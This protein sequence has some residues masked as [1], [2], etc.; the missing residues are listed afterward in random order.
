MT[1]IV[2]P[3]GT[4]GDAGFEG[5]GS[6]ADDRAAL[7]LRAFRLVREVQ[8][9][10]V[11]SASDVEAMV[12]TA[13]ARG[14]PEATRAAL[15]LDVVRL[16]EH[17]RRLSPQAVSRL[18]ARA[19][20]DSDPIMTA[21]ALAMG[22]QEALS[23]QEERSVGADRD[24][25]HASVLL[26]GVRGEALELA[27]AHIEC[28]VAYDVRNLWEL[29]TDHYRAAEELV[30]GDHEEF[31]LLPV[32]RFNVAELHLNWA[33]ALRE[34]SDTEGLRHRV[35]IA[36]RAL[37]DAEVAS[38]PASWATE[39]RIFSMLL[40]AI[41]PPEE[42]LELPIGDPPAVGTYAGYVVLARALREGDLEL[43]LRLAGEATE[44]IDPVQCPGA[45]SLA[46]CL[47]G[48]LESELAGAV[49]AG[50]AYGCHLARLRWHNRLASLA[51]AESLLHG[52]RLRSE[53]T[54]LAQHAYLDD[55]TRLGNR[56]ALWRHLNRLLADGSEGIGI[57]LIDLDNFKQVNDRFG[58]GVGD[59]VLVRLAALLRADA[60]T[61]D[62]AVRL[63]GDEFMLV[64]NS[65]Q[66]RGARSRANWLLEAV[67]AERWDEIRPGLSVT[68]SVGLAFGSPR[69]YDRLIAIADAALY[70]AKA[71]LT[72]GDDPTD[73][74]A[75]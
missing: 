23:N 69:E 57:V 45:Y 60:G 74:A 42:Q 22:A 34:L 65:A 25:A 20:S 7:R 32:I 33:M 5:L 12:N 39:L 24:L 21:L 64:L 30:H 72:S 70:R 55:L 27:C 53:H 8:D 44:M 67:A 41:A 62:L 56:R 52:E 28:A 59:Q 43:A 73:D 54:V 35:P 61:S 6:E 75:G 68:A 40:D 37:A 58:H 38:M 50:Q 15:F 4:T 14:W 49:T 13:E 63:G 51:S 16:K 26:E 19:I 48:E 46:C 29:E 66:P 2:E 71:G 1:I 31:V 9:G 47:A 10:A 36:R 11:V 3:V 18:L 17:Q